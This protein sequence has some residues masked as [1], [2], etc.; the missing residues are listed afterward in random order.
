MTNAH[1]NSGPEFLEQHVGKLKSRM[2]GFVPGSHVSIR[3]V[4]LHE[5]FKNADWMDLYV[6]G[7]TG[8]RLSAAQL[9]MLQALWTYTSYPDARLW[10]NRVAALA[11]SAR[12]SGALGISAALAVS[13]ATI[14]GGG[15]YVPSITFLQKTYQAINVGGSIEESVREELRIR[16]GI[17]GYGRPLT[18]KDERLA[19]LFESAKQLGMDQGPHLLLAQEIDAYLAKGRWRIRM[20]YAAAIAAIAA[21]M[22]FTAQEYY[23]FL[24]P[25]FMAGMLPCYIEA[26]ESR[27][28]SLFPVSCGHIRYIGK[29]VRCWR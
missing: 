7:I 18:S 17:A 13:E 11:G 19:H 3:G 22:G 24:F 1:P 6:F 4:D 26:L 10:N 14:Y 29:Q 15:V 12:S 27:E 16:R 2:G 5:T 8:R 9:K 23:L 25:V 20:N 28:S 21:D